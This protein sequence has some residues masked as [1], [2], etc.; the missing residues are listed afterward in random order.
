MAK[1]KEKSVS[2]PV[3]VTLAVMAG[4]WKILIIHQ[5][6]DGPKRFNQLQRELGA[7]THRTLSQQLREM[8]EDG[9]VIRTDYGEIPPRVD[10]ALSPRGMTLKPILRAMEKW[11]LEHGAAVI[12]KSKK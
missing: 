3:E 8:E 10:Y 4:R 2:C 11:A 6:V 1:T 5:L 9:L 12:N 7:I